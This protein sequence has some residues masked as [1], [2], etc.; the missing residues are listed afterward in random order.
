MSHWAGHT[1]R[2]LGVAALGC[3]LSLALY[4]VWQLPPRWSAIVIIGA[5]AVAVSMCLVRVFSDLL[6]VASLFCLPGASFVKWVAPS[7]YPLEDYPQAVLSGLFN[8]GVVDII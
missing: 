7:S 8:V 1:A 3:I 2:W 6:L 4:Q 5:A